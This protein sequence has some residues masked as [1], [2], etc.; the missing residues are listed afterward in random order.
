MSDDQSVI[1]DELN[2]LDAQRG[3]LSHNG[4][5]HI[6]YMTAKLASNDYLC[7]CCRM[8]VIDELLNTNYGIKKSRL[9]LKYVGKVAHLI[10]VVSDVDVQNNRILID[11]PLV[12]SKRG[13]LIEVDSHIWW[14]LK[15]FCG[16]SAHNWFVDNICPEVSIGDYVYLDCLVEKYS[17]HRYG[18]G[19]S[20]LNCSGVFVQLPR[21]IKSPING[22]HGFIYSSF[23][24]YGDYVLRINTE[25]LI[26]LDCDSRALS[27]DE[28]ELKSTF[29][30]HYNERFRF[31]K[32]KM[33]NQR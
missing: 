28:Y 10:G 15:D 11:K 8:E 26:E 31:W 12:I 7:N 13:A 1:V 22:L 17:G 25:K 6:I 14:P 18:I 33:C 2:Y 4:K 19:K 9:S 23:K 16:I 24:R 30:G 21:D 3:K 27:S 29:W 5:L 32:N 20:V